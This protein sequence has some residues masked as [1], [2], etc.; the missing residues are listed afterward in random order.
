M[1]TLPS[2][3]S[4]WVHADDVA[5]LARQLC[6]HREDA[7]DVAQTSLLKAAEHIDGFRG[8]S[9][10]RTWLHRITTNECHML[11]RR[12]VARSLDEI[13]EHAPA[14]AAMP[15]SLEA[16][17]EELAEEHLLGQAVL[18]A[19]VQLPE[20]QRAV[21]VLHEGAGLSFAEV[22]RRLGTSVAAVSSLR[23]RARRALRAQVPMAPS[24]ER[25]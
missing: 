23:V 12:L 3:D 15:V 10:M 6:R 4:V 17:P 14:D 16:S 22:A 24:P 2:A 5:R 21:L 20:R 13:L 7:E 8:E 25:G 18:D 19:I 9:T 11:R 1:A